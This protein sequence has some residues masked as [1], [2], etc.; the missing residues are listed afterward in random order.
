MLTTWSKDPYP[1]N[2]LIKLRS[3]GLAIRYNTSEKG[4][5][6]WIDNTLIFGSIEL[7]IPSLKSFILE[8]LGTMRAILYKDLLFTDPE[9]AELSLDPPSIDLYSLKDDILNS[10]ID[11]NFLRDPRNSDILAL[12]S[13]YL[14]KRIFDVSILRERFIISYSAIDNNIEWNINRLR[15]Y[16][17]KIRR[18]KERLL[19]LI[20]LTSG[21]P[22]RG[23]ELLTIRYRNSTIG[24]GRNL[25]LEDG[26]VSLVTSYH[27]GYTASSRLK[28]IHRYISKEVSIALIYYLWLV[29]PFSYS[30]GVFLSELDLGYSTEKSIQTYRSP[31]LWPEKARPR[32]D[33][34]Q[35]QV[36]KRPRR[37]TEAIEEIDIDI[38]LETLENSQISLENSQNTPFWISSNQW[39]SGQLSQLIDQQFRAYLG[40]SINLLK[41]RHIIIAIFRN[42][43]PDPR[44][45]SI[46]P[47]STDSSTNLGSNELDPDD[48][49]LDL[50]LGSNIAD[51]QSGHTQAIAEQIYARDINELPGQTQSKRALYRATSC[52]LH[53]FLGL[54]TTNSTIRSI[55][56]ENRIIKVQKWKKYQKINLDFILQQSFGATSTYRASQ[57]ANLELILK[58]YSPILIISGT[59]SGKSLYFQIP[60]LIASFERIDSL[61]VIILPLI[62]LKLDIARRFDQ[63]GLFTEEWKI[64]SPISINTRI[65]LITYES[66]ITNRFKEYAL[67]QISQN[68]L[69]RIYIDECHF[70]LDANTE[71]RPKLRQIGELLELK[72]QFIYLTATLSP[73]DLPEWISVAGVTENSLKILRQSTSRSNISYKVT[74]IAPSKLFTTFISLY[75]AKQAAIGETGQII[76]Y[77]T[78]KRMTEKVAENIGCSFF[79]SELSIGQKSDILRDFIQ[80]DIR[81][82]AATNA[83]GVGIDS[84]NIRLIIHLNRPSKLRSYSQESGRAGRDS[85]P[86]EALLLGSNF[87]NI[88][89]KIDSDLI[90]YST[91]TLCRRIILDQVLDGREDRIQC[92]DGEEPCDI[93]FN[94]LENQSSAIDRPLSPRFNLDIDNREDEPTFPT[95]FQASEQ[96]IAL[97]QTIYSENLARNSLDLGLLRLKLNRAREECLY[98]NSTSTSCLCSAENR[99]KGDRIADELRTKLKFDPYSGCFRCYLP[100]SLCPKWEYRKDRYVRQYPR[101]ECEF[102]DILG[103]YIAGAILREEN[104][105]QDWYIERGLRYSIS[106]KR[107]EDLYK[108]YGRKYRAGEIETNEL[109][110][111]FWNLYRLEE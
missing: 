100:Y 14:L 37:N 11:F 97:S 21:A 77:C 28:L 60:S 35:Y 98:C 92:L 17:I 18:F 30:L 41:W 82:L 27:K 88:D 87:H 23:T 63:L 9:I 1:F 65:L 58:G 29:E 85:L 83:F 68:R 86:S 78:S 111:S 105:V 61:I 90:R 104:R 109:C 71:F 49:D 46:L 44:L 48:S 110:W 55:K 57:K 107:L 106:I 15:E 7:A 62:A 69:D 33:D 66:A 39:T 8:L 16:F 54:E 3:Y 52:W 64:N 94:R 4:T 12:E 89:P 45:S 2:Y 13:N 32:P 74:E 50:N 102:L 19:V 70:I 5:S 43:N 95:E 34:S 31:F 84:P 20:H 67:R 38:D 53:T 80:Q 101:I 96:D 81:V 51:L 24:G 76:I 59:G 47:Q 73:T 91:T 75:R 6:Y 79:H 10:E 22:A 42:F 26:L 103:R 40:V 56:N 99:E 93:C 72:V 36:R 108:I 25:Y